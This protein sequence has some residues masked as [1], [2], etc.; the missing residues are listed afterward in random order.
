MQHAAQG[1]TEHRSSSGRTQ[2]RKGFLLPGAL[3]SRI[4]GVVRAVRGQNEEK[5]LYGKKE[6]HDWQGLLHLPSVRL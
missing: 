2:V 3:A 1:R 5:V 4:P 6:Q